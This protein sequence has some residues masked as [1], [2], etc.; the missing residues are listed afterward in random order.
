MT[1]VAG[2]G[3]I[4]LRAF[5]DEDMEPLVRAC[6]D[7]EVVRWT[8]VPSPYDESMAREFRAEM[9]KRRQD[10]TVVNSAIADA[11]TDDYLGSID[12]RIDAP[13]RRGNIGY[14]VAPW[15]RRRGV[16]VRAV[17]LVTAYGF[18]TLALGRIEIVTHVDN[19]ASQGVAERAGFEREAVLRAYVAERDGGLADGVVFSRV[20]AG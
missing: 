3:V 12:L 18:D 1:E 11:S 20:P 8:R 7:P 13:N 6:R 16:A 2:D 9:E 17:R 10:G 5:R 14:L 19:P 15:A 4:T